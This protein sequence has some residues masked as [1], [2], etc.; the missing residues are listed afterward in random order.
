MRV[1][2]E[3]IGAKPI[4]LFDCMYEKQQ[5][6]DLLPGCSHSLV[7][8]KIP[9]NIG[10]RQYHAAVVESSILAVVKAWMVK[11]LKTSWNSVSYV[12]YMYGNNCAQLARQ[13]QSY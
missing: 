9:G 12:K 3:F 1:R 10:L 6:P 5:V 11:S 13:I 7:K 2:C 4:N 8:S